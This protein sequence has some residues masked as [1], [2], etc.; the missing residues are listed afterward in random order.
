MVRIALVGSV[1]TPKPAPK[2]IDFLLTVSESCDLATVA[3]HARRLKG[4]LQGH[5]LTA[6]IFLADETGQYI[7]RVCRWRECRPGVLCMT[8]SAWLTFRRILLLRRHSCS[9]LH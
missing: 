9:G 2:D 5:N 6:D 8:T 4:R 7:G 3:L 1:T